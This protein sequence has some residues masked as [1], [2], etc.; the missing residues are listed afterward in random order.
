MENSSIDTIPDAINGANP[1][2]PVGRFVVGYNQRGE[3]DTDV[4]RMD[5][6]AGTTYVLRAIHDQVGY[7]DVFH[8][9]DEGGNAED[10]PSV[11]Y[12]PDG[13]NQYGT[14]KDFFLKYD[15]DTTLYFSVRGAYGTTQRYTFA[16]TNANLAPSDAQDNTMAWNNAYDVFDGGDGIDTLSFAHLSNPIRLELFSGTI[17]GQDVTQP[18]SRVALQNIERFEGTMGDD[19]FAGDYFKRIHSP[20]PSI[21]NSSNISEVTWLGLDGDDTLGTTAGTTIFDGGSGNDTADYSGASKGTGSGLAIDVSL[22]RGTGQFGAAEGDQLISIENLIGSGFD[23]TL[24][25]DHGDN[26]LN[27]GDGID[28]LMGLGGDDTLDGGTRPTYGYQANP[29]PP[30]LSGQGRFPF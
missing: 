2:V 26:L 18:P 13:L 21:S 29:P 28:R 1:L 12:H 22:L 24:T 16:L 19:V 9:L 11:R 8:L 25:G 14:H 7:G 27:G 17:E 15:A 20:N 30:R 6:E 4:Y 23:D 3:R 10:A 5:L